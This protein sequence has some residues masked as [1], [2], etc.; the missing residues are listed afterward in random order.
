LT[1]YMLDTNIVSDLLRNPQGNAAKR[2]ARIGDDSICTSII[3]AAELRY[4]CL[5]SGSRR[6][7]KAVEDLL[8]E[9][10]ILPFDVPADARYGE[11]RSKL[12][13]SGQPIGSN[14][15]LI[16]AHAQA[17]GAIVVTANTD[18]F[19]RVAGLK[20]ENWLT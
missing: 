19:K 14:D 20:V 8:D 18:E 5:K 4:G 9:I 12:E 16:A 11:I 10:T 15:L 2:V 3:V 1:R 17:V 13:V 6:L 7:V